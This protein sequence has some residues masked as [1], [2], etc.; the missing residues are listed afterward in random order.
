MRNEVIP[1]IV[2][3]FTRTRPAVDDGDKRVSLRAA[4]PS[5]KNSGL[6][7]CSSATK[8][9]NPHRKLKIIIKRTGVP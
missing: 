8:T 7:M 6:D 5:T 4:M 3:A 9:A 2:A 1:E